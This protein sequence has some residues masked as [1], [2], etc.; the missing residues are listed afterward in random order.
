MAAADILRI[1]DWATE[2]ANRS[3]T[4]KKH[5]LSSL[6]GKDIVLLYQCMIIGASGY[7]RA[8][9]YQQLKC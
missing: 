9:T 8:K 1:L 7:K 5:P 6:I 4:L 3:P 2:V